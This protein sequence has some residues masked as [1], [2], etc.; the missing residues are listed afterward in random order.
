MRKA[1]K[2]I[3]SDL[4]RLE[5]FSGKKISFLRII[6]GFIGSKSAQA[7]ILFRL[8]HLFGGKSNILGVLITNYAIRS[9]GCEIRH[10][11]NIGNGL[12]ICHTVGIVIS[13][14]ANIGENCMIYQ[15]VT[16]G[17][18]KKTTVNHIGN[19]VQISAGAKVLCDNVG[20]NVVIGPNSVVL[21]NVPSNATVVGNPAQ[22][23]KLEGKRVDI[24]LKKYWLDRA[25]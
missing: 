19:N 7:S 4:S 8:A 11:A 22:I 6:I 14:S 18:K 13:D 15:G 9:T 16:I 10:Q 12:R 24:P 20:D 23:V 2:L 17:K 25:Q 5:V 21:D 3:K 1:I